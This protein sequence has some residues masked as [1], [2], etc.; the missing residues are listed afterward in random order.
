MFSIYNSNAVHP[1]F[2]PLSQFN[3][4]HKNHQHHLNPNPPNKLELTR[5]GP[6][7]FASIAEVVDLHLG[8]LMYFLHRA[9]FTEEEYKMRNIKVNFAT[10]WRCLLHGALN[11]STVVFLLLIS[12]CSLSPSSSPS[13]HPAFQISSPVLPPFSRK[14]FK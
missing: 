7:H 13:H 5:F 8:Q 9:V 11:W 1:Q 3:H 4:R 14:L 2:S 10:F 6:Y 12:F